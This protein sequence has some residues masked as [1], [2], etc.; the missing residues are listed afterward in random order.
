M[1]VGFE[2]PGGPNFG[3]GAEA[4]SAALDTT[5]LFKASK[6]SSPPLPTT[7]SSHPSPLLGPDYFITVCLQAGIALLKPQIIIITIIRNSC[8][9][10][11]IGTPRENVGVCPL[12]LE[13]LLWSSGDHKA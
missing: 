2:S 13:L 3:V 1:E 6:C 4:A 12:S 10:G 11:G 9:G 8:G 5:K 7:A